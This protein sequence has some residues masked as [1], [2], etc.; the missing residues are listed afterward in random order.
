MKTKHSGIKFSFP[1]LQEADAKCEKHPGTK[2]YAVGDKLICGECE[3]EKEK[4][5]ADDFRL[6]NCTL[7]RGFSRQI[8]EL[9]EKIKRVE[10][11]RKVDENVLYNLK[12]ELRSAI[13]YYQDQ[14]KKHGG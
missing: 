13:S 6:W 7:G 5:K 11:Q 3:L 2:I 12:S 4:K 14:K 1:T 10:G 8:A 9:Q